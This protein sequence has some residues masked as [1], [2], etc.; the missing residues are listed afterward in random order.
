VLRNDGTVTDLRQ[1]VDRLH[2]RY[3]QL[4]NLP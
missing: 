4:A 3:L 2:A 1:A